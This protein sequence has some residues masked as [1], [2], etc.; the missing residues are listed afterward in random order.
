M[1]ADLNPGAFVR[2]SEA[3]FVF[4]LLFKFLMGSGQF[5]LLTWYRFLPTEGLVFYL[6]FY[7]PAQLVVG[8]TFFVSF[9]IS[10]LSAS[11]GILVA[12]L[13]GAALSL[14]ST[15]GTQTSPALTLAGSS[16]VGLSL[17]GLALLNI[18]L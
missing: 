17:L 15:L 3:L 12:I 2:V 6:F 16:F 8:T 1:G 10:A 4:V 5:L 13:F 9:F 7:Y 18:S 14:A 11:L